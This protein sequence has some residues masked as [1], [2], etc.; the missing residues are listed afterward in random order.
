MVG[1]ICGGTDILRNVIMMVLTVIGMNEVMDDCYLIY[2]TLGIV[3]L[4][5][6]LVKKDV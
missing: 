2:Q 6:V 5:M 1:A 3:G 4:A